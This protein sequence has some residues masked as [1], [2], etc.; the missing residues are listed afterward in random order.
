MDK[1]QLYL[2]PDEA[3]FLGMAVASM[4]EQIEGF[5]MNPEHPW[6]PETRKMF[7]EM[8]EAGSALEIKLKKLGIPVEPLPAYNEG[9]EEDFFTKPS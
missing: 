7:K 6:N 4:L 5:A 2:K 9:D 3:R 1:Q 8:R